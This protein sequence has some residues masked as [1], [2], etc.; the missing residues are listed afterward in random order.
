MQLLSE[1]S[2]KHPFLP[3]SAP[4]SLRPLYLCPQA[5]LLRVDKH[6]HIVKESQDSPTVAEL[7]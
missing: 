7:G 5:I 1:E 3:Q 4:P 2:G 6:G